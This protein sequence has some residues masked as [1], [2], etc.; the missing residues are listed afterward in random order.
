MTITLSEIARAAGV[1]ISTVS[2]TLNDEG[3]PVKEETRQ[4][5]L[6]LAEEM[7]YQPNLVARGLRSSRTYTVGV[8]ADDVSQIFTA[9]ILSGICDYLREFGYTSMIM[10]ANSFG[11]SSSKEQDALENLTRRSVDGI[12]FADTSFKSSSDKALNLTDKPHVFVNRGQAPG[13]RTIGPDDYY[14]A[15]LATQHLLK[16]GYRRV[17]YIGG[18]DGWRAT[19]ERLAGYRQAMALAGLSSEGLIRQSIWNV[20]AGEEVAKSLLQL[21]QRPD[22]IFAASDQ[23]AVGAIYAIQDAGLRIPDDIAIVGYDDRPIAGDA[24]PALTTVRMPCH[25]M[26]QAAAQLLLHQIDGSEPPPLYAVRGTLIVRD[27]CGAKRILPQVYDDSAVI[28]VATSTQKAAI[29]TVQ[30][31]ALADVEITGG[32][33]KHYQTLVHQETLPVVYEQLEARGTMDAL[34]LNWKPGQPKQP[35]IFWESDLAKWVEAASYVLA[36]EPDDALAQQVDHVIELLAHAQQADGYLNAYYTVVEPGKRFT[37]LRDRHELYCAGHLI[38]AAVAHYEATGSQSLLGIMLRYADLINALFGP[39]EHQRHGYPG[40][41]EIELALVRLYHATDDKRYLDLAKYFVDQRGQQPHYYDQEAQERGEASADFWARTYEY[42]QSHRPVR[43]HSAI[44]GHAVRATY[45]YAGAADV[46]RETDDQELAQAVKRVAENLIGRRMYVTGG[47]GS[48]RANEGFTGDYD[49]PND[50]AYAETCAAIGLFFWMHR[51]VQLEHDVR[52]ADV[53]ERA[54]YNGI[55]SGLSLDGRRFF[56]ENLLAVR[57]GAERTRFQPYHR[58]EWFSTSC[59]PPNISRLIASLGQYMYAQSQDELLVYLYGTSAAD[60]EFGEQRFTLTQT[61]NYPWDGDID[62]QFQLEAPVEFALKLRVPGW[63]HSD[64]V[65]V[66]GKPIALERERGCVTIRRT[67][68]AG[69]NHVRLHLDMPVERVY[70]QPEVVADQGRVALQRGPI[71]YCLESVDNGADLDDIVLPRDARLE[72]HFAP[73][74]LNGVVVIEGAALRDDR[75]PEDGANLYSTQAPHFKPVH[76]KAVPY[77][78]WD[79]RDEG[80]MLVWLREAAPDSAGAS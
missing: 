52:Y 67:W 12:I 3:Y 49:L 1:S 6:R 43:E 18:P 28:R 38:E 19:R 50:T 70:A 7:G 64:T 36:K 34:K 25:E 80:D 55:L 10:H 11:V 45:L 53:M 66:D 57:R 46:S 14:G 2:R 73:D 48:Q 26:G 9:L 78:A 77:F 68:Q 60:F 35:H 72:A 27:S 75:A 51:M 69:E 29:M 32:F 20:K 33:W 44:V 61:T 65:Q 16:L 5:I 58:Q 76:L 59:C 71:V 13:A 8:I 17:A 30:P 23:I 21:A 4:R 41:E 24:R 15:Q 42:N 63:C 74:L 79:N 62:L 22:A 40:H 39:A 47:I 37:N 31:L 56:Y 54:L